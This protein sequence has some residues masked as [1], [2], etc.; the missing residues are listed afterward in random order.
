[1]C[2]AKSSTSPHPSPDGVTHPGSFGHFDGWN[3]GSADG[4]IDGE[5]D[6]KEL[7][8]S[9]GLV[10]GNAVLLGAAEG[11]YD[12]EGVAEGAMGIY[13]EPP[14]IQ[15]ASYTDFPFEMKFWLPMKLQ[16]SLLKFF[17]TTSVTFSHPKFWKIAQSG[18]SL[19]SDGLADGNGDGWDE[20]EGT[21]EG[22]SE[23][24]DD[25]KFEGLDDDD[26]TDDGDIDGIYDGINDGKED[27]LLLNE[28]NPLGNADGLLLNEGT[29]LGAADGLEE[30]APDADGCI[31]LDGIWEGMK[32]GSADARSLSVICNALI[33]PKALFVSCND[34]MNSSCAACDWSALLIVFLIVSSSTAI[35]DVVLTKTRNL[36]LTFG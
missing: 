34:W 8:P 5:E 2:S 24:W 13:F 35:A 15:Q 17:S 23:G 26:G 21:N 22:T 3:D 29:S 4:L 30:G 11:L 6:G 12:T 7:G 25:G 18:S 9:E 28:G 1:M 36:R 14:Q 16:K 31:E 33:E 10:D 27:G 19:H 32:E 20:T